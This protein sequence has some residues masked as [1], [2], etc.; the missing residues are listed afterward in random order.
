MFLRG[1]LR[2]GE[3][4]GTWRRLR[5]AADCSR[6]R[7]RAACGGHSRP[8][9]P[10]PSGPGS[11]GLG[12]T[13]EGRRA[14][15][16]AALGPRRRRSPRGCRRETRGGCRVRRGPALTRLPLAAA[17]RTAGPRAPL[18]DMCCRPGLHEGGGHFAASA[19]LVLFS[20]PKPEH[21]GKELEETDWFLQRHPEKRL[22]TCHHDHSS[23]GKQLFIR[24]CSHEVLIGGGVVK[25][26]PF[27][28]FFP[29]L[30]LYR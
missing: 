28:A 8:P 27:P 2:G 23:L 25:N 24:A 30:K 18:C 16:P 26:R 1:G 9:S 29:S 21:G 6:L 3:G 22:A 12:D 19:V 5:A 10:R 15:V 17:R 11:G 4:G 14:R 13:K 7:P 20:D